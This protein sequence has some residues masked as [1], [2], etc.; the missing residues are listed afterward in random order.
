MASEGP[1][2]EITD[3]D[4]DRIAVEVMGP[5]VYLTATSHG[6]ASCV[7]LDAAGR[8][9]FT[10]AWVEAERQAEAATVP[11]EAEFDP[12]GLGAI[13]PR[14]AMNKVERA[15]RELIGIPDGL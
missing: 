11:D 8:D 4:G 12:T 6:F 14:S 3:G 15:A 5:N 10:R 9:R 1:I 13:I 7:R 2:D